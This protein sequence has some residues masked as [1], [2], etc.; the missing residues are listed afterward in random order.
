MRE[1]PSG[2]DPAGGRVLRVNA[3]VTGASRPPVGLL[4][5]VGSRLGP[6]HRRG[7]Q[8]GAQVTDRRS[9][10]RWGRWAAAVALAAGLVA[11]VPGTAQAAPA[12]EDAAA[13]IAAKHAQ[14]GGDT[15][16]LGPVRF[17]VDCTFLA[18][19]CLQQFTHG[20]I[21]WTPATGAHAFTDQRFFD[22]WLYEL[23]ISHSVGYPSSDLRCGL[24][25]GGCA[26][27]L[28]GG[29]LYLSP[30]TDRVHLVRSDA[31]RTWRAHGGEGG[32]LGYPVAGLY[33]DGSVGC[34]QD[35]E[36]GLVYLRPDGRV[37]AVHGEVAATW[38]EWGA[39]Y[40]PLGVPTSS[41]FCGLRSGGCGQHFQEGSVYWSPAT[42][43]WALAPDV[44][45]AWARAGWEDGPLGYPT[46]DE[47]CGLPEDGCLQQFQGG[48]VYW[49]PSTGSSA[50]HGP[51]RDAWAAQGWERGLLRYP[52]VNTFCGLPAGGCGQHFQ[53]GSV[54]WSPATG[55]RTISA[56]VRDGYAAA[57]W[58]RGALG[59][60]TSNTFCGLRDQGCGQ[61]FQGG[62]LYRTAFQPW[63][64]A[65]A[66]P[67][68]IRDRWAASG[69]ENGPLGMP[70]GNAFCG[71]RDGACG[72]HFQGGSI[73]QTRTGTF[74][75]LGSIKTA[76]ARQGWEHGGLGMPTSDTFCGLRD[77]GCGQHFQGGSVY[78]AGPVTG[79][80]GARAVVVAGAF[81]ATW[82]ARGWEN[83]ALGYPLGDAY[84]A[85][86]GLTQWFQRG[87]LQL[88][89]GRVH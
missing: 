80:R 26:Q 25:D 75:V 48:S 6:V 7:R 22:A 24:A 82:A 32:P 18:D 43:G 17:P 33:C 34:S 10:R 56:A 5:P 77:G 66:V 64:Q 63:G 72:Q 70:T 38:W 88:R 15:G 73:Y 89:N 65:F 59:Y 62:S 41:T 23:G 9:A 35:F 74:T 76:W 84:Q 46:A 78:A 67:G 60:P 28:A 44:R 4:R 3:Q 49:S 53:G 30:A 81:R 47:A 13:P 39:E 12:P 54:Y 68:S 51:V 71:L 55:A 45:D 58:E 61:H 19:G 79:L 69:W 29:A 37:Q 31:L 2:T 20:S 16:M 21:A 11:G 50:V 36:G 42:G 40:G 8:S 27:E 87:Y 52:T 57:G 85:P 14:L 1:R 86:G 83:G